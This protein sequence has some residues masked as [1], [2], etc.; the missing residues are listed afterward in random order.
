MTF[1]PKQLF[2][3]RSNRDGTIDSICTVC[4]ATVSR[5]DALALA[6]QGED[7]HKCPGS[8]SSRH[9]GVERSRGLTED[10]R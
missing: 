8:P 9:F 5:V 6:K 2:V 4:F 3:Y 1:T 10:R 7:A